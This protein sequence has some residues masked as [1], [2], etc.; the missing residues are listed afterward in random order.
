M[1]AFWGFS[2]PA[3]P[4]PRCP[5]LNVVTSLTTYGAIAREIVG[6]R[7]TVTSI[8]QGDED[9]HF[10]Q[11]KP[12]FVTGPARR[13]PVRH[14]RHGPRA[15]GAGPARPR[16]QPQDHR[17]RPRLRRGLSRH[18]SAGGSHLVEPSGGRHPCGWQPSHPHRS[19]QRDHHRAQHPRRSPAGLTG[20]R[21]S[22]PAES[23]ISR[24]GCSR[25]PWGRSWSRRSPRPPPSSCCGPTS[26]RIFSP[27]EIPGQAAARS[28]GRLAQAG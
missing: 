15:L 23:R 2:C 26:C 4:R 1:P 28:A 5:A 10:V 3:A 14:H 11:P 24:N 6:D 12:S 25:P 13:R 19:A 8:A 20:T 27:A 7:G 21:P 18:R 9:P 22:L 16:R 17:R